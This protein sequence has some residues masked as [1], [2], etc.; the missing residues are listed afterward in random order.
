MERGKVLYS[1]GTRASYGELNPLCGVKIKQNTLKIAI[2]HDWLTGMRGG[3]KCLEALCCI[4]P[5]AHIYTLICKK[6]RLSPPIRKMDIRTSCLQLLPFIDKYYRYLLP[7]MPMVIE[8]FKLRDYDLVISS[9]HCIAK[10]VKI[11]GN[12]PHVCYCYTPMRYIWDQ[13]SQYFNRT[14]T[15]LIARIIFPLVKKYLQNWDIKSSERVDHFVAISQNVSG[16]IKK[17]YNR[18]SE[19]IYPPL[20]TQFFELAE[21]IGDYYLIVSAF[22]PYKRIDLAIKAFNQLGHS[23]KIIG[24]GQCEK[25]LRQ[26]AGPNIEFLGYLNDE[27]TKRYYSQCKA[28]IFPGEEDFGITPLEAQASGRP[29]IAFGKGG[30]LETVIPFTPLTGSNDAHMST[31]IFFY[32][33]TVDALVE[34]V[35]YFEKINHQ[36]DSKKIREHA[37]KFDQSVFHK[38][39]KEYINDKMSV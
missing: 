28:F 37:Y 32:E 20:N 8:R 38:R 9:S 18:E 19:V 34:A 16:R 6:D 33:Q 14:N 10:G 22:A 11:G 29:V 17:I 36:F 3:E 27:E 21:S 24:G 1:S 30:A 13:S 2:V 15:G 5:D 4:F 39:I 26:I 25:Y 7:I 35:R 12:I 23:L 31:G